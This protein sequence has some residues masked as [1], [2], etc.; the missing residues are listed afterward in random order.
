MSAIPKGLNRESAK[1]KAKKQAR[2]DC[3]VIVKERAGHRCQAIGLVPD[4][5]CYGPLEIHEPLSRARGGDETDP[6][7]CVALCRGHHQHAHANPEAA[8]VLGLLL[9]SRPVRGLLYDRR[10]Q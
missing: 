8:E 4:V 5:C 2:E 7:Q 9:P 6:D 10:A 1:T 3:K